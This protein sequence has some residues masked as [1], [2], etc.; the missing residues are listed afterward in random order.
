MTDNRKKELEQHLTVDECE[1]MCTCA[2]VF[3]LVGFYFWQEPC[4]RKGLL[5]IMQYK[6][7]HAHTHM[8]GHTLYDLEA[9]SIIKGQVHYTKYPVEAILSILPVSLSAATCL[10]KSSIL[11]SSF[12]R[13][14]NIFLSRMLKAWKGV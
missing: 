13:A 2:L 10:I 6:C 12:C 14:S 4:W 7:T 3:P 1:C 9:Y 11:L 8:H 5:P